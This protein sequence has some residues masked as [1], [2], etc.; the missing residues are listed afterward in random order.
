MPEDI[1]ETFKK[2]S[3]IEMKYAHKLAAAAAGTGNNVVRAVMHAVSKDSEKHALLYKVLLDIHA[4]P[5]RML[6]E[7]ESQRILREIEEHI[8]TEEEMLRRVR[9]LLKRD[10]LD[11]PTKFIL[12]LILRDEGLHHAMLLAIH[13][14]IIEHE[15]LTESD[16]WDMIWKD[17]SFHGAPGG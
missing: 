14:M 13:K 17:A 3:E 16:L 8:R 9:Q 12:E 2:L 5:G 10:D 6:T 15:T 4:K 7:E 1:L 11:K